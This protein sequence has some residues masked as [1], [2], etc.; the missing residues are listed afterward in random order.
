MVISWS[1]GMNVDEIKRKMGGIFK[2]IIKVLFIKR[3]TD[4]KQESDL[5]L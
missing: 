1:T 3:Q 5:S 4:L 2:D